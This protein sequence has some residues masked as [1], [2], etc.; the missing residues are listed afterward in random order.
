MWLD[1]H[2]YH[3]KLQEVSN[4]PYHLHVHPCPHLQLTTHDS[5]D[6]SQ[7]YSHAASTVEFVMAAAAAVVG[8]T[9]LKL[10]P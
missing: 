1:E 7:Y 5:D 6:G 10:H 8:Q 3:G 9:P 2:K 4:P